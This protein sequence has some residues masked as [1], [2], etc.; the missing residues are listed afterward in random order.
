MKKQIL[1]F[2]VVLLGFAALVITWFVGISAG[3]FLD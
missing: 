1:V 3:G 2:V